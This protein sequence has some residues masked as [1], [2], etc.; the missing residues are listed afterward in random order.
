MRNMRAQTAILHDCSVQ[1]FAGFMSKQLSW[2]DTLDSNPVPKIGAVGREKLAEKDGITSPVQL[3]GQYLIHNILVIRLC[4]HLC[5]QTDPANAAD[6]V[7][8][9]ALAYHTGARRTVAH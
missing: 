2:K 7:S 8:I 4:L 3:I 6:V 5:L 9:R 1:V